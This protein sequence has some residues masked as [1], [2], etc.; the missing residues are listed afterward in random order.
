MDEILV[1]LLMSFI[2]MS[3]SG[4][5]ALSFVDDAEPKPRSGAVAYW[6]YLKVFKRT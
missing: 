3:V 6:L 4:L 5:Q 2:S 1:V